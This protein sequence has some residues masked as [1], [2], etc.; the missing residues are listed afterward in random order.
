MV[1]CSML[2]MLLLVIFCQTLCAEPLGME[3]ADVVVTTGI[4][5]RMPV[6][7]VESYAAT[8]K[9][10]YCFSRITGARVDETI[11]HVWYHEGREVAKIGLPVRSSNWRTW[12][13][14]TFFKASQGVWRVDVMDGRGQ[15]LGSQKFR[16][17]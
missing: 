8:V 15:I 14:K 3:A 17:L 12:S 4:R 11:W 5:D 1:K 10:L 2:G 6:D 7:A 16:L 9:N 13:K